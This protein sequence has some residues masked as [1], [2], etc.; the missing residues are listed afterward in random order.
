MDG[1][2]WGRGA[3]ELGTQAL[4]AEFVLGF[5]VLVWLGQLEDLRF[6]HSSVWTDCRALNGQGLF[7]SSVSLCGHSQGGFRVLMVI[8]LA[9]GLGLRTGQ[10][11]FDLGVLRWVRLI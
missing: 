4:W 5:R 2:S 3:S 9:W 7:Q 6:K 11:C 1:D 8:W 10:T